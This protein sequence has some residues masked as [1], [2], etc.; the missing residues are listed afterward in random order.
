M[1]SG[2]WR[3]SNEQMTIKI[4]TDAAHNVHTTTSPVVRKFI[5]QPLQSLVHY[6]ERIGGTVDIMPIK[7][8]N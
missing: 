8:Q 1:A 5:G 4:E 3:L 2:I 6:M 7:K